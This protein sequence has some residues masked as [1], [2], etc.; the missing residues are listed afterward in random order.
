[1]GVLAGEPVAGGGGI[2]ALLERGFC[3]FLAA[4]SLRGEQLAPDLLD[5]VLQLVISRAVGKGE[6]CR[7]EIG[8]DFLALRLPAGVGVEDEEF[9]VGAERGPTRS[10]VRGE[11]LPS[12][13]VEQM[14]SYKARAAQPCGRA[15]FGLFP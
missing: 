4:R 10:G 5:R 8:G 11:C 13:M 3:L 1:M 2:D 14:Q 15:P 6:G 9:A 7:G 12:T